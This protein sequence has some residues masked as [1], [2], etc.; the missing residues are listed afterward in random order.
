MEPVDTFS[1]LMKTMTKEKTTSS[2]S[3]GPAA[4]NS[5]LKTN[6]SVHPETKFFIREK[7]GAA[8]IINAE[9]QW[10]QSHVSQDGAV[11]SE[12]DTLTDKVLTVDMCT[13]RDD[14]KL[15]QLLPKH[16]NPSKKCSTDSLS[17]ITNA[18]WND[19]PNP[20]VLQ[21]D[22][23]STN[24]TASQESS[25][26]ASFKRK[27]RKKRRLS[28]E[29]A[30]SV[31]A[32]ERQV[33][34]K[35]SDSEEEHCLWRGG[36]GLCPSENFHFSYINQPQKTLIPSLM[37]YSA[38]SNLPV[39]ISSKDI[40]V[41]DLSHEIL[42][43]SSQY[44]RL[45]E[46]IARH[47]G[48]MENNANNGRSVTL[49]SQ[50]NKGLM[51]AQ[52]NSGNVATNFKTCCKL[53]VEDSASLMKYPAL[54]VSLTDLVTGTSPNAG[55]LWTSDEIN[56]PFNYCENEH[57]S[58]SCTTEVNSI[59]NSILP[60]TE[61]NDPTVD[62]SQDDKLSAT[63]SV[64]AQE[65]GNSGRNKH[66]LCERESQQQLE[67]DCHYTDQYSTTLGKTQLLLSAI[68]TSGSDAYD[69]L[70]KPIKT[71][72]FPSIEKV[73]SQVDCSKLILESSNTSP[74]KSCL[75]KSPPDL[76]INMTV[77]QTEPPSVLYV[78]SKLNFS[79]DKEI[80]SERAELVT[81]LRVATHSGN[82]ELADEM[83]QTGKHNRDTTLSV[84]G[85]VLTSPSDST[86]VSSC[87]TLDTESGFPYSHEN[88]S[89]MSGSSCLS[90]SQNYSEEENKSLLLAKQEAG[91]G[92]C[93]P[94]SQTVSEVTIQSISDLVVEEEDAFTASTADCEH[95]KAPDKKHSVFAMSSFWNEMEKL[96]INDI[97]GLRSKAA[98]SSSLSPLQEIE[99]TD[100]L[101]MTD[102]GF[103]NQL[104]ESKAEKTNEDTY[105]DPNNAGSSSG[106]G[107]TDNSSSSKTVIW[108]KEPASLS[109]A[110]DVYP[111]NMMLTSVSDIP[112][113]VLPGSTHTCL[114]Q[115]SKNVSVHNLSALES[116]YYSCR[117]KGQTKSSD[118][119][120][121][122][123]VEHFSDGHMPTKDEDSLAPSSAESYRISLTDIFKYLFGGKQ[124]IPSQSATDT[125]TARYTD[126]NSVSET[127]DHFF[128]E[129]DTESFFYPLSTAKEQTK[130][131][132]VPIFSCSRSV[133]RNLQYP[134]AYEYFFASSS[135]DDSSDDEDNCGPVR[136]VTRFSRIPSASRICTDI[137]DNFFTDRDLQQ[138]LFWKNTL[139][140]RNISFAG[141]K[142]QKQALSNPLSPAP[143]RQSGRFP[144]RTVHSI[145]ALGNQDV[146]FSDPLLY[147]LEDRISR[148]L[149]QQSL[150]YE[151]F[152]M[153]VSNPRLDA[154]LLPIR[155]SDMC[156]LC[157]AFASWVLK[158]TNPQVGDAWKA[159]LLANVSAL[160]AIRY[161]RKYV[162]MEAASSEK[163]LHYNSPSG[164]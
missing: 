50:T 3:L 56:H 129:F 41:N 77:Q 66:T 136:V 24:R 104:D 135:S 46:S 156:L 29:T 142:V 51:S 115:I 84:S 137:Y 98:Q 121:L 40:N 148:Q 58:G 69:T 12:T 31:H 112:K 33:S 145:N 19:S 9:T 54:P 17:N 123:K 7:A 71:R 94:I 18:K 38:T 45:Q 163:K 154:S 8:T 138:N 133:N 119:G 141:S 99:E 57:N 13:T 2:V 103:F 76:D 149:A 27:R 130:D 83:N 48:S 153:A 139:S 64:L 92:N 36:M 70:R 63:K 158:T 91:D 162:R 67:I 114:R 81:P 157:I 39:K 124:T 140:F 26:S 6:R 47:T 86:P 42:P 96:T 75:S 52:N 113:T 147:H 34:V 107:S 131:K 100:M 101:A 25:P 14:V 35:Q 85:N 20:N 109:L 88:I 55:R 122:D 28:V 159:V 146:M 65:S 22:A 89:D 126:G 151:D 44:R 110:A 80:T 134:E 97:L 150:R 108:E 61:S 116:Q 164:L 68:S 10:N 32:C 161:L 62:V 117:L 127:Y 87:G 1:K 155:H 53:Q 128:S 90:V 21:S 143:L 118:T 105:T 93:T 125:I 5:V 106:S 49:L 78:V 132:L 11:C 74:D 59:T 79:S 60:S 15:E 82:P 111:K 72:T 102:S 73:S 37:S 4:N 95:A 43:C 120:E 144:P 160:S 23:T 152:Q 16:L 30:E